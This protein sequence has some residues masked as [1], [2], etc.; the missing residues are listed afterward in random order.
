MFY[1]C[2]QIF[3]AL[4]NSEF[5]IIHTVS[6]KFTQNPFFFLIDMPI[7]RVSFRGKIIIQYVSTPM[8]H[9]VYKGPSS[10]HVTDYFIIIFQSPTTFQFFFKLLLPK[11]HHILIL[12]KSKSNIRYSMDLIKF[13]TLVSAL[14]KVICFENLFFSVKNFFDG[15]ATKKKPVEPLVTTDRCKTHLRL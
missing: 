6:L 4:N 9:Q 8:I 2:S 7:C 12:F 10:K 3:I 14:K 15:F 11:R 1:Y 5:C 13:S